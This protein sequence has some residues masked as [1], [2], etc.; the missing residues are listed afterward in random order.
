MLKKILPFIGKYKKETILAPITMIG[1]VLMEVLIPLV[2]AK[3]VD[4]GVN[5]DGGSAYIIKMGLL[6]IVM[7]VFSL[8]C[9][10]LSAKYASTASMGFGSNLR[11]GLFK[12]IS[13]FSF[14]NTDKFST[15]KSSN[16]GS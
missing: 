5:G 1:E 2:M 11:L 9:G 8:M 12:K 4:I 7:A 15:S 10:M 16:D 6:M 14:S 3:I 13:D